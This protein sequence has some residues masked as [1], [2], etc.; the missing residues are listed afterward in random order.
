MKIRPY[1]FLILVIFSVQLLINTPVTAGPAADEAGQEVV[2]KKV[3]GFAG[4]WVAIFDEIVDAVKNIK[5]VFAFKGDKEEPQALKIVSE[6]VMMK[7][8]AAQPGDGNNSPYMPGP[9]DHAVLAP[10]AQQAQQGQPLP[11]APA[12]Q[13]KAQA[14]PEDLLALTKVAEKEMKRENMPRAGE[15]VK[16]LP[17]PNKP[18]NKEHETIRPGDQEMGDGPSKMT[19]VGKQAL[20]AG[21]ANMQVEGAEE[22]AGAAAAVSGLAASAAASS[23]G[24]SDRHVSSG[25]RAAAQTV[26][27]SA[28][29][30]QTTESRVRTT[31]TQTATR[32]STTSSQ[33]GS[34]SRCEDGLKEKSSFE[35]DIDGDFNNLKIIDNKY[36]L[37]LSFEGR[38]Q[39]ISATSICSGA[40]LECGSEDEDAAATALVSAC[41]RDI[42]VDEDI[43]DR[44]VL[45]VNKVGQKLIFVYHDELYVTAG[46]E[47]F[48]A[49]LEPENLS[50]EGKIKVGTEVF[51]VVAEGAHDCG[52]CR[53]H[54]SLKDE[55]GDDI[56]GLL[57][58]V[59]MV[60][61]EIGPPLRY[62]SI[63][64]VDE[65]TADAVEWIV[66][67]TVTP[68]D[69]GRTLKIE[70]TIPVIY[71]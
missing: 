68:P 42:D 2:L 30:A 29:P 62:R 21:A 41:A 10:A 44:S 56:T 43:E 16:P 34:S 40:K 60:D 50:R 67:I 54:F 13:P 49:Y 36:L 59:A 12:V 27:D 61:P 55:H 14:L 8:H 69:Y 9:G 23:A 7:P 32:S 48:V 20:D 5:K 38:T 11:A 15:G 66:T 33:T 70:K 25:G 58:D 17:A 1:I 53:L 47:V 26:A 24:A 63:R 3:G 45:A 57:S 51:R 19:V 31:E 28:T 71:Q 64:T 18:D 39:N 22:G 35:H 4:F 37:V 65:G 46:D 6:P 52:D